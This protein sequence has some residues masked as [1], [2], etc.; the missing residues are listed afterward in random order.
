ML[1]STICSA[2]LTV[3]KNLLTRRAR[4]LRPCLLC[5]MWSCIIRQCQ[6]VMFRVHSEIVI[7]CSGWLCTEIFSDVAAIRDEHGFPG[8]TDACSILSPAMSPL[9]RGVVHAAMDRGRCA[10][11]NKPSG[12]AHVHVSRRPIVGWIAIQSRVVV[13]RSVRN[14]FIR[15]LVMFCGGG[16][17]LLGIAGEGPGKSGCN[18][19]PINP[20]QEVFSFLDSRGFLFFRTDSR[21]FHKHFD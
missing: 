6:I 8:D 16:L 5:R 20:R 14:A 7:H 18:D 12:M 11:H 9:M 3:P 10:A 1:F 17:R 13:G 19:F 4:W 21:S 15:G 2:R